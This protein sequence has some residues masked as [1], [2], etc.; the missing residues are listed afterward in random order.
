[1]VMVHRH[2]ILLLSAAVMLSPT[3]VSAFSTPSSLQLKRVAPTSSSSVAKSISTGWSSSLF[4][5]NGADA[6]DESA[7]TNA[8]LKANLLKRI[9]AL[10]SQLDI[11]HWIDLYPDMARKGAIHL[12]NIV[13]MT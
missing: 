4:G 11:V 8:E 1:M 6:D 3:A 7:P 5:A 13:H 9:E 10:V 12:T 2:R